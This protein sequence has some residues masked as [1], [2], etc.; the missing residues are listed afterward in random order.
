M[1]ALAGCVRTQPVGVVQ[2]PAYV[3]QPRPV[4]QQPVIQQPVIQQ[5]VIQQ[6]VYAPPP[7]YAPQPGYVAQPG[8][9]PPPAYAPQPGYTPQP[10]YAPPPPAGTSAPGQLPPSVARVFADPNDPTAPHFGRLPNEDEFAQAGQTARIDM[11]QGS[12][13]VTFTLS[14]DKF[15]ATVPLLARVG[16]LNQ[17]LTA[18]YTQRNLVS[19]ATAFTLQASATMAHQI[20]NT[21]GSP[22]GCHFQQAFA[23]PGGGNIPMFEFN[24]DRNTDAGGPWPQLMSKGFSYQDADRFVAFAPG[25]TLA[26]GIVQQIRQESGG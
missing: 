18:Q 17:N 26:P 22:F 16:I 3:A 14:R 10:G 5:P 6:P 20:L 24:M 2:Q 12:C 15:L 21:P 7:G 23:I 4:V 25:F 13:L 11:Q 8:Y 1:V 19:V 9:P